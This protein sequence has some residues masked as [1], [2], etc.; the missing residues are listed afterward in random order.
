MVT[1]RSPAPASRAALSKS[2]RRFSCSP[3][4]FVLGC[5]LCKMVL[6]VEGAWGGTR[7]SAPGRARARRTRLFVLGRSDERCGWIVGLQS[8]HPGHVHEVTVLGEGLQ[9]LVRRSLGCDA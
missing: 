4:K 7:A 8:L 9:L 1:L 5:Q 6:V 2:V 3:L